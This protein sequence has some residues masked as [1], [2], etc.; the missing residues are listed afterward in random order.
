M[1][2]TANGIDD[3]KKFHPA[4]SLAK[5]VWEKRNLLRQSILKDPRGGIG[6]LCEKFGFGSNSELWDEYIFNIAVRP[7]LEYCCTAPIEE[8]VNKYS[9]ID[10]CLFKPYIRREEDPKRFERAFWNVN[11]YGL[12][13]SER[14]GHEMGPPK[15][16]NKKGGKRT[17][18]ILF[19]GPLIL[20]HTEFLVAFLIGC[21]YFKKLIDVTIILIDDS[22]KSLT[23]LDYLEVISVNH[24]G[25]VYSRLKL[26]HDLCNERQFDST[27]WVAAVQNLALYMGQKR[28][29]SQAYW[30]MKYHSIVMPTLD[31]YAAIGFGGKS[32]SYEGTDWFRGRAFPYLKKA[33]ITEQ[34]KN[35][36]KEKYEIQLDSKVVGCFVREEKTH[37][38][39]FWKGV[40]KI[41]QENE[42]T[43]FVLAS[44]SLNKLSEIIT[45]NAEINKR[46]KYIGWI[47][48][49]VVVN[50]IDLYF[51]SYPRGSCNTIFEAI[52][53]GV[54]IVMTDTELNRE[55]SALI[56]LRG[57]SGGKEV[58]GIMNTYPDQIRECKK[59]LGDAVYRAKLIES[60]NL[61]LKKLMGQHALFAKDYLQYFLDTKL[62]I[63]GRK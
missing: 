16:K 30:S 39:E 3:R 48:T 56:Y 26:V 38:V 25:D 40:K 7:C 50:I 1:M 60:Q 63:Q 2:A 20:A 61:L 46:F 23:K 8:A 17:I 27:V 5:E 24:I 31:K 58:D 43:V 59:I 36:L 57:A 35:S 49:K 42:N 12:R 14:F 32:F 37:S 51:D 53:A 22:G 18:C 33:E 28:S 6:Q 62:S 55:S 34:E 9:K 15:K 11:K 21:S 13:I 45:S 47:N 54:P 52:Q 19:K 4:S 44:Q 10:G 29:E 41:L